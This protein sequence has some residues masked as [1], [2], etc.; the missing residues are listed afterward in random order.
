MSR[1]FGGP[2][3]NRLRPAAVDVPI[4]VRQAGIA[5]TGRPP[6]RLRPVGWAGT[7]CRAGPP[8]AVARPV[9]VTGTPGRF[10]ALVRVAGTPGRFAALVRRAGSRRWYARPGPAGARSSVAFVIVAMAVRA[11]PSGSS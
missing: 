10:A 11:G 6:P 4:S 9:R 3:Q 8:V 1:E 7:H 2:T 5:G